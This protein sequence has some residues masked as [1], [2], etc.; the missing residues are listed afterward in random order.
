MARNYTRKNLKDLSLF[1][2]IS[3]ID[4]TINDFCVDIEEKKK[5]LNLINQTIE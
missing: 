2:K 1:E 5:I 4:K 3:K